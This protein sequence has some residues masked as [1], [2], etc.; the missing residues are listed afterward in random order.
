MSVLEITEVDGN[1]IKGIYSYTPYETS[2][3]NQ[4]G[5]Y[6]VEGEFIPDGLLVTLKAG[7]WVTEPEKYMSVTKQDISAVLYADDGI[8]KGS[9]QES[10]IFNISKQ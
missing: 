10:C 1:S 8:M 7:D 6:T 4:P 3:W 2:K 9:G 5:S